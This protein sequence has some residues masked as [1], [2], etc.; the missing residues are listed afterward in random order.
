MK[1]ITKP[2]RWLLKQEMLKEFGP[3]SF[4]FSNAELEIEINKLWIVRTSKIET[5]EYKERQY[6]PIYCP[7]NAEKIEI[8]LLWIWARADKINANPCW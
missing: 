5:K 6:N 4:K 8:C 7:G 3:I 2:W 1:L